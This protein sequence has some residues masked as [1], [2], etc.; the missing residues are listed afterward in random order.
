[1]GRRVLATRRQILVTTVAVTDVL[2]RN[3]QLRGLGTGML[4][5]RQTRGSGRFDHRKALVV[6]VVS[7]C[8]VI[9]SIVRVERSGDWRV[10]TTARGGAA[11]RLSELT[12]VWR[13]DAQWAVVCISA[14]GVMLGRVV[15]P[16]GL[17]ALRRQ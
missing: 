12:G 5:I 2:V 7:V 9:V 15:V 10:A 17:E 14:F 8:I 3:H 16:K 1:M 11:V 6:V 13:S 4:G